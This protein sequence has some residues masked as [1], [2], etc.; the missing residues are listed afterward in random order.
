MCGEEISREHYEIAAYGH[1]EYTV[2][3]NYCDANCTDDGGY[4]M[5]VYCSMCGEEI[6][7]EHYV[8]T[9][10]GHSL[11][12]L[13]E[14]PFAPTCT[15][16]GGYD[17]A[18]YCMVCGVEQS[19]E[20][21]ELAPLGHEMSEW[22]QA[23]IPTCTAD[24]ENTRYCC[25]GCGHYEF[26]I[27]PATGH[28]HVNTVEENRYD[29]TCT[30]AGGYDIMQY[31]AD[32][33]A[34]LSREHYV[35]DAYGHNEYTVQENYCDP[36][37]TDD[38]GYDM[39]VYCSMC[40]E[41]ISRVHYVI[42]ASGHYLHTFD[43]NHINPT[44]TEIGG[45]D[46]VTYCAVCGVEQ[47][48]EHYELAPL[49]HQYG[50]WYQ[51]QAPTEVAQGEK[52][53]DCIDCGAFETTPI[54]M[55][56]HDHNNWDKI[57]LEAVAPTCTT[58]GLTAGVKC[59]GCGK[60][61][62][63]QEI[64]PALGHDMGEWYQTVAPTCTTE[65]EN[66]RDCG[67]CDYYET[68]VVPA[69]GHTP[70]DAVVE[71]HVDPTCTEIGGYDMVV[72]CTVCGVELSR[73]RIE[74]PA[75]GHAPADA[76]EENRVAPTCTKIGGYDMVVYCADCGVELSREHYDVDALGHDMGEWYQTIAPTCTTE[77]ENKRD[78]SRCNHFETEVVPA[79]GHTPDDVVIEDHVDPTCTKVGGY[80]NVTYC[81]VCEEELS[82][83][84]V[85]IEA[86][87][88]TSGKIVVENNV[89]PTCTENGSYNNVI[90]CTACGEELSRET[91][92]V[93]ALRH[94]M[95]EW[96]Q[97]VAPT[98]TT[99]GENRRDC[100]RCGYYETEVV[101]ANGHTPAN[102]VEENHVDPTCTAIGG[103]DMA[104][105]CTV[106]GVELSREHYDVEAL[107]HSHNAVVTAPTC[108]EQGYTTHT[109]H[110]GDTFVDSYVDALGHTE[111][112]DAAV[113]P[114][115][116]AT[117]LTEGKH[118]SVCN[119]VLVAQEVMPTNGHTYESVVTAP[120]CTEKGYTTHTCHCGDTYV[121]NEVEALGHT[122]SDWIVDA[123]AQIGVEGSKHKECTTCGETLET[124]AIEA[125][126]EAP[127]TEASE[128]EPSGGCNGTISASVVLLA[129]LSC[130]AAA[131]RPRKDN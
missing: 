119:A 14:N 74:I 88:H 57:T 15:T 52:R 68:E 32:C 5:I 4:D 58:F 59:S 38:G 49:G 63:A 82:R 26:E 114:T 129:L 40:G 64:V 81:F 1:N 85:E 112:I 99:E 94:N 106:C 29:P 96:Y 83:E 103:Y 102:A 92:A 66:R 78:C 6:S 23:V 95:G 70:A 118:C 22:Y 47:S 110:C 51:T 34:E 62:I 46:M 111:A 53:R 39:V 44:C 128:T 80:D 101:P 54:A 127:T 2:Q 67:R 100:D 30:T 31:C 89:A 71:N 18:T 97:T 131:W 125:L 10:T 19:R 48:R 84:H 55:L 9:A 117:G 13:E 90:Y 86:L 109:C 72:Y 79:N 17:V 105:Y 20:H 50:E 77:G 120:T 126:T 115:C 65:S 116:T 107:G 76:V 104:V 98:C 35:L 36:N 91:V 21:Y 33:S 108:M 124:E 24:G 123:E 69:N 3:E 73:E 11:Y 45:Y 7:R 121:D 42:S 27:V 56:G 28:I 41:E 8:I 130:F 12:T 113:A 25:R 61:L 87:G 43:E 93:E 16:V 60:I 122:P 75:N 37:C